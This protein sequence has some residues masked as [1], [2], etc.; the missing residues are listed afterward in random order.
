[1]GEKL[2]RKVRIGTI[3]FL[4]ILM[5]LLSFGE[6]TKEIMPTSTDVYYLL[7]N[8]TGGLNVPFGLYTPNTVVYQAGTSSVDYRFN[9]TVCNVNEKVRFGF[10]SNN[11]NTWVRVKRSSDNAIVFGPMLISATAGAEGNINSYSEAVAGPRSIVGAAGYNDTGFVATAAVGGAQD[12]YFEFNRG[13]GSASTT[14]TTN[15][16]TLRYFDV[17]VASPGNV[18]IPGRIW[19]EAWQFAD[20]GSAFRGSFYVYSDDQIV[21]RLNANGM[22]P[23]WFGISCNSTGVSNTG[24]PNVD[25]KSRSG[26]STYPQYKLFLNDPDINCY[27]TGT[28]GNIIGV[29][30]V[31][32]CG[33]NRCINL[34]VDKPGNILVTLDLNGTPGYQGGTSDRQISYLVTVANAPF[35]IPWDGLD[36]LGNNIPTGTVITTQIDFLNGITH[37]PLYDCEDNRN[38]FIVNLIRP[39]GPNPRLFWDDS[40]VIPAQYAAGTALDGVTNLTGCNAATGCHRWRNRGSN[41]C[42]P[43]SETL[44]SWWYANIVTTTISYTNTNIFTD[45]NN[46]TPG[47]G[48][49]S[50]NFSSCGTITPIQ[51]NGTVAG[52]PGVTGLWTAPG[53]DGTF[54]PNATTLNA[55]YT[56]GVNDIS[57]GTV[58]LKL[59]SV[60]GVCPSVADSVLITLVPPPSVFAGNNQSACKNF[61][62]GQVTISDATKNAAATSIAWT[63]GSGT[64]SPN[65]TTLAISYTPTAAEMTAGSVT[66]TLT[67]TGNAVCPNSVST[68]TISYYNAPTA[69]AGGNRTTCSN[70]G[71]V[72]IPGTVSGGAT[73]SWTSASGCSMCFSSTSTA[74]T[75][76]TPSATDIANGSVVLTLTASLAG[77][78]DVT[79]NMTL[80]ITPAPIP[81]AGANQSIC[82]NNTTA[83]LSGSVANSAGATSTWSSSSGCGS[84]ACFSSLTSMTPT[85]TPSAT[86]LSNGSV[87]LTLT[88]TKA[89]CNPV[90]SAMTITYT[91]IPTI[92]AGPSTQNFCADNPQVTLSGSV[93]GPAGIGAQWSGGIGSFLA[94]NQ[95]LN[96][97]YILDPMEV[98]IGIVGLYLT[99][100]NNGNC[101]PVKDS[102]I[103]L[104]VPTPTVDAGP[105][106]NVCRNNP[107]I[108]VTGTVT[109]STSGSP[110]WT[111]LT[112]GSAGFSN[113]NSLTTNYTLNATDL[114]NGSATLVLSAN[115]VDPTCEPKRD[116]VILTVTEPPTVNAGADQN[117]ICF[118]PGTVNLNGFSSTGSGTWSG[119]AGT[120]SPNANTANAVYNSTAGERGGT[121]TLTYTSG[122]NGN[123]IAVQD[124]MNITFGPQITVN[125]GAP[126]T[127]CSNNPTA[128]LNGSSPVTGT[129]QWSGGAGIFTPN[130]S[131]LNATYTP[132]AAEIAAGSV[133][134]TLTA[135]GTGTCTA[136]TSTVLITINAA[137][138]LSINAGAANTNI[139]AD[140]PT[141]S[142]SVTLPGGGVGVIWTGGAGTYT[143]DNT[144]ASI[145]YTATSAEILAGTITLTATTTNT[146]LCN[147]VSDQIDVVIAPAPTI[148]AGA[149]QILCGSTASVSLNGTVTGSTGGTWTT[150]GSGTFADANSV[151]TTYTPSAADKTAGIVTLTLTSTGNGTCNVVSDQMTVS[152]TVVPTINA[153]PDITVCV[154]TEPAQLNGSGTPAVWTGGAGT[155]LPNSSTM[156][157][158][159]DPTPAEEAA[160]TVTL[161]LTT[162]PSG[163]CPQV[164]DQVTITIEPS[165]AADAGTDIIACGNQAVIN[166]SGSVNAQAT[167]GF[168]T[169]TG[170]GTI[171]DPTALVTTYT[172][173]LAD[174]TAGT[175]TL[176]LTTTGV[177]NCGP[178]SDDVV[179]TISPTVTVS[180]GPDQTLCQDGTNIP[181]NGNVT[182][183]T[184]G[185]WTI[186]AGAGTLNNPT[187][188]TGASYTP[189]AADLT[190][191]LRLT[192]TGNP[193]GCA[194]LTDDVT[195]TLSPQ[196]V[197]TVGA[198]QT[199]C[200]D[201]ASVALTGTV[202]NASGQVWSTTGAGTF[203][204]S[205]S[206]L[207]P[208][209]VP[210]VN[211]TG[212]LTF[213]LTSTGNGVCAGVYSASMTVN[214]TPTPTINAGIDQSVCSNNA[215]IALTATVTVATGGTWVTLGDGT[216]SGVSGN[217]L[218]AT[219]NPGPNDISN[220]SVN[221]R[222]TSTGNGTCNAVTDMMVLTITTAPTVNAGPDR[223]VCANNSNVTLAGTVTVATG[224]TWSTLGSGTF[225]GTSADGLN[226]TYTPSNADTTAGLARLVLT[227]TGNG[228]CNPVTDTLDVTITPAPV[229]NAGPDQ[230]I[231]ADSFFVELDANF[232][233]A[234]A[235][236]WSTSGTGSFFNSNATYD[237]AVYVPS[238]ADRTAGSVTLTFTTTVHG[239]CNPVS[240]NLIISITPAPTV[241][242]GADQVI[243]SD[244]VSINVTGTK[245]AIPA[246]VIWTTSGSGTYGS[247]TS[248]NTT[249][250]PSAIDKAAGMV[251]LTMTS[252]GNGT[253]RAAF[254]QM[255]LNITPKPAVNTGLDITACSDIYNTG[256][257][258]NPTVSDD[259]I[260]VWSS[261]S[262][263]AFSPTNNTQNAR[264][265]PSVA[266]TT[267]KSVVLTLT[268]YGYAP[269]TPS[270]DNI[271][272]FFTPIPLVNAGSDI[273]V[274]NGSTGSLN[275]AVINATGGTWTTSGSGTFAPDQNTLN[276]TYIPSPAD[277][278]SGSVTLTL[279][280]SGMG[281]CNPVSDQMIITFRNRPTI[282]AG[283]DDTTC[284]DAQSYAVNSAITNAGGVIWS[285][286]S[287]G[288]F[289]TSTSL[290]SLY[291]LTPQDSINGTVVLTV[292][293]TG[294][295]TCAPVSDNIILTISPIPSA[296]A[297]PAQLN[298]CENDL[299]ITLNGT[300]TNA[301]G[302]YWS[303]LGD[304]TFDDADLLSP[305][306]TFGVN[307]KLNATV[308]ITFISQGNG[309]CNFYTDSIRINLTPGTDANAGPDR[310]IC[311]TDYPI[312]LQGSGA[313]GVWSGGNPMKYSNINSLTS[314]YNP[315]GEPED[316]TGTLTLT[317]TP[318]G[319]CPGLSDDVTFN[320][321]N[322]PSVDIDPLTTICT[323][324]NSVTLTGT[325][326]TS[327]GNWT[328]TGGTAGFAS[329]TAFPTTY[330]F[331]AADK[332]AGQVKFTYTIPASGFCNAVMDTATIRINPTPVVNAG[333]DQTRCANAL[334]AVTMNGSFTVASG[335]Q[336]YT[337]NGTNGPLTSPTTVNAQYT[338]V[339]GDIPLSPIRIVIE[340][341]GASFCSVQRDT[342]QITI[343]PAPTATIG[344]DTTMCADKTA[345]L[346]A[347]TTVA[348][349]GVW[350][351]TGTGTFS[352]NNSSKTVIYTPSAADTASGAVTVSYLTTGNGICNA[353]NVS[354]ILTLTENPIVMAGINDTICSGQDSV[355]LNAVYVANAPG[356]LWT[357]T[358]T[359]TF[360]PNNTTQSAYYHPS[361]L[362]KANGGAILR[363]ASTGIVEC[364]SVFD[365]KTLMIIP[366]PVASVNAG[367]DQTICRD[368][369]I[370]Q[371]AGFILIATAAKWD[372]QGVP[373]SGT[374]LPNDADLFAQYIPSAADT[375]AGNVILR[376]TT[377]TGNGICDP[378]YDEMSLTIIDIPRVDAGNTQTVCADTAGIQ[379]NGNITHAT[380]VPAG[381]S[382]VSSGN[383]IFAPNAFVA[384][385]VYIPDAA[386]KTNGK[387]SFTLTSTNNG[388]CNPY[389]DTVSTIIL[390]P[391]TI[392]A[393][394][395]KSTCA[396]VV[397]VTII[398]TMTNATMAAWSS[399]GTGIITPTS[400]DGLTITY[401]PSALDDTAGSVILTVQT[402]AGLGS[403]KPVNDN[404]VLTINPAPVVNAG[405]DRTICADNGNVSIS[406]TVAVATGGLWTTLG[407]G[408]FA[409]NTSFNTTYTPSAADTS[410]QTV[411]LVF[412]ST[413]NGL[414]Q[415]EDDTVTLTIDPKPVVIAGNAVICEV[416]N[417]SALNGIVINAGGGIW[418][419]SGTGTFAL[420]AAQLNATYY[421][422]A[423]DE[424]AGFVTL[425]LTSTANGTC[426]SVSSTTNLSITRIPIADAGPDQ[427]ICQNTNTTVNATLDP[428]AL[429]YEW[430]RLSGAVINPN[431]SALNAFVDKDTSFVLTVYDSKNCASVKDTVNI[432]TF[433]MPTLTL[434][435]TVCLTD[436][437]VINSVAMP[438][439]PPVPG[440]FQWYNPGIM[441]GQNTPTLY[442]NV[443]GN[444][445]LTFSYGG[446][447]ATSNTFTINPS[448]VVS[449]IDKTNCVN[450]MTVL[451]TSSVSGGTSFT[452]SWDP[453][454]TI[455]GATNTSQVTVQTATV[456]DTIPYRV[457]VNNEFNCPA[458][459][460]VYLIS[461]ASPIM[462]LV[463]DTL[464]QGEITTL[465]ANATNYGVGS[466][467]P[468]EDYFPTYTWTRDGVNLN[469]NTNTQA[470]T[471]PGR[472]IVEITIGDCNNNRD[473]SDILYNNFA[474]FDLPESSKFC[475]ETQG[476]DTLEVITT[477]PAG[478]TYGYLWSTNDTT[479][480]IEVT[481]EG[482]YTV[483]VT[484]NI[485]TSSC[486]I[487]DSITVRDI[488][489]PRVFVPNV[490]TPDGTT[491]KNF[492]IFGGH[493]SSEG[494]SITIFS[495]WGEV[496]FSSTN[497]EEMQ[498]QGWDGTYKGKPMPMGVYTYII[499]YNGED[500]EYEGPFR[501]DGDVLILR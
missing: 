159:Y 306:Y 197:V 92:D 153:G 138:V 55:T 164:S 442:P 13:T 126:I 372:C 295:G 81:N 53:G 215:S 185:T 86:D 451:S 58:K 369:N 269:C 77:C 363:L 121:V 194:A 272:I 279:T 277:T 170:S 383:G 37:L 290:N 453:D 429:R 42:P 385:P 71:A 418:T 163:A 238:P 396:N 186:M 405:V 234:S 431:I 52:P 331:S 60:G 226:T 347:T 327:P 265:F 80:T 125:A 476:S 444:Y 15:E 464:C 459:D 420:N 75:T 20:G 332:T 140:N 162:I 18:A 379:L 477:V 446:C 337:I 40:N 284:A 312:T 483:T 44:N 87:T 398:G 273:E 311:R 143:P 118:N 39:G 104:V 410:N 198:N 400:A 149:D 122:A 285:S 282:L 27:P 193:P 333:P 291:F 110:S 352:P 380:L 381:Y 334:T 224:G 450:N 31:T 100:I 50:N 117:G 416:V 206:V 310:T 488:C 316:M 292:T 496:I 218:T 319:S 394:I 184:G 239:S 142:L 84:P 349:G 407:S 28:Y 433:S 326:P 98:S 25:Q 146:G 62:N 384:N 299:S 211:E 481:Q 323:N 437:N 4:L 228:T 482:L 63:G 24:N 73:A 89:G 449:G 45:A 175:V 435:G 208:D 470:V 317:L 171:G 67:G 489:A 387:V 253:C 134:L 169:T 501:K 131:T 97:T 378:V 445:Y 173:S 257:L 83:T 178:V 161:T 245:N 43:C 289:F 487:S 423:A 392:S 458:S 399:S 240:D 266:D 304:G 115:A 280:S 202:T 38:G 344:N 386:D 462:D 7:F 472:Y 2:R 388:T 302:G 406:G 409:S 11:T 114:A 209:Y 447:S 463:N 413:G 227:S 354:K 426:N 30:T 106:A 395:D 177:G 243:C 343:T 90:P 232:L 35:C 64:V 308:L 195:F 365:Y 340:T 144:T 94:N 474:T 8:R 330:T 473:T 9:V 5:S 66:L 128:T 305:T 72:T 247:N 448:P 61:N 235:G 241:T 263:G 368:E 377:T 182:G 139:C 102:I 22:Q 189:N 328:S 480:M 286:S 346:T 36:G 430:S 358:G 99:S 32:G 475:S 457:T 191:T 127:V 408:T 338:P 436:S 166:I 313:S 250:T 297:G 362:D 242:V 427:F 376:L 156:N 179:I 88:S 168:W 203:T 264:Y 51:L 167:G 108:S 485:G 19:S 205:N 425:T 382:W 260:V 230:V 345:Q 339:A 267:S 96:A 34:I 255:V 270:S 434:N 424:A 403:C 93:T 26:P 422:S 421:P 216:F 141:A 152:F 49:A 375:A 181:L 301:T 107:T 370:A 495:R 95:I 236:I 411:S 157:A 293:T 342:M 201:V 341:T 415:P 188:A 428:L 187:S 111:S 147:P 91:A 246:G 350:S 165:P 261:P 359:G 256:V 492:K 172:P 14:Y 231:C 303:S 414:C 214:I 479:S 47:T 29:P 158:T 298:V 204:P 283:A 404:M 493:Y 160:G 366:S 467:P 85:Y 233:N 461:V 471:T 54:S 287:G 397:N 393:G 12:Y 452:Y 1:M 123:C 262:G 486:P 373:C 74:S 137:P 469:N 402:T 468:I 33:S 268:A 315:V 389:S 307:D 455:V 374:F 460:S 222:I 79:S 116:T 336:W 318:I 322:G 259:S 371:L 237:T 155:F 456:F 196:P 183:A 401:D 288:G 296:D 348:T 251:V 70:I 41:T 276:A 180:A 10:R 412:T 119:G 69:D 65:R 136:P 133:T 499:Y 294:T 103:L 275:G 367:F 441:T 443:V 68:V 466:I 213:T 438:G 361:A 109:G 21:T 23:Y 46:T 439:L 225:S 48:F 274:C 484:S 497:K 212:V 176:T 320:F 254:D 465:V 271:T 498:T 210:A 258:L 324:V 6:G 56:P 364:D 356:V 59:E 219:Y 248:L 200:G 360:S 16:F 335:I 391:P 154:N 223:S 132:T 151:T 478:F 112:S 221:L 174:K 314:T 129:G 252:T 490:F 491:N 101:N 78:T 150:N 120:F 192:T 207:T 135:T 249:Y 199:V 351:T 244:G 329:T 281:T 57:T 105:A 390:P 355:A 130:S 300:V 220:G 417:G 148:N 82:K 190:V 500:A 17:T 419:S 124:Q 76:Y 325:P 3:T 454:P 494:F 145:T 309:G 229:V 278:V 357:T 113:P 353:I 217:G 432:R 321:I 440:T